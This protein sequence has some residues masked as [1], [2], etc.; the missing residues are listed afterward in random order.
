MVTSQPQLVVNAAGQTLD[1]LTVPPS[2]WWSRAVHAVDHHPQERQKA[3]PAD[4]FHPSAAAPVPPK[5]QRDN[6]RGSLAASVYTTRE[7]AKPAWR[8]GK[9]SVPSGRE[10]GYRQNLPE[11]IPF[12][13]LLPRPQEG[14]G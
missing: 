13:P 6:D 10:S 2:H 1:R 11:A 4:V 12:S 5:E 9:S 7:L 3:S 8:A 14:N